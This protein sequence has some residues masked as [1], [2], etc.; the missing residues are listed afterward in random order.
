MNY[1]I[2][3][4]AKILS[5][6]MP[7]RKAFRLLG[8]ALAAA[9]VAAI[10]LDVNRFGNE[11]AGHVYLPKINEDF[12]SGVRSGVNGTPTFY[13]NGVRHDGGWD[14]AS[15]MSALQQAAS[16]AQAA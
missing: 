12:V 7:R 1:L 8:G 9:A 3:D 5:A 15:L 13:I 2:D 11:V 10:G 6:P 16:T 14:Y 4:F